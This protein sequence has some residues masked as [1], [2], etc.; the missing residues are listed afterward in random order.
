MLKQSV[1]KV[2]NK[3][4]ILL[5]VL[6]VLSVIATVSATSDF[7]D[8]YKHGTGHCDQGY[9]EYGTRHCDQGGHCAQGH[10]DYRDGMSAVL[11]K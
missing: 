2:K 5:V 9:C 7:P 6:F 10:S 1:N 8:I 11:P 3:M 4:L